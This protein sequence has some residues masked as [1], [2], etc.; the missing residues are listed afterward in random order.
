MAR[1][2][3]AFLEQVVG[4]PACLHGHSDGAPVVPLAVLERPD[5]VPKLVFSAGALSPPT[6]GHRV[7]P[8]STT[9]RS[10]SSPTTGAPSRLTGREHFSVVKAKLTLSLWES[11]D[12]IRAFAG[13]DIEAAVLYPEDELY[14]IAGESKVAHYEG[15]GD[16][17]P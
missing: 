10:H 8:I 1:D 17:I 12:A 13:D 6:A 9:R 15:V 3:I 2:T 14:L 16:V 5:L 7:R 11:E 4:G